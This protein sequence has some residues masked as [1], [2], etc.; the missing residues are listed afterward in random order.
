MSYRRLFLVFASVAQLGALS[1][2]RQAALPQDNSKLPVFAVSHPVQREVTDYVEYTGRTA[3]VQAEEIK[4][5]VTGFLVE[6]SFQEGGEIKKDDVLFKIDPRPYQAQ[7]DQAEA[8]VGLYQSQLKLAKANY[9]R[10][11]E[12][13]KRTKGAG[14]T[15]QALDSDVAQQEQAEAAL[16]A[17]QASLEVYKLNLDY[18]TVKSPIDGQAGR[19]NQPQG[20]LI[21]QDSTLLTTVQTVDP[22][23]A[24]FDMDM[25]SY[26]K[27]QLGM[28][29]DPGSKID[30]SMA[31]QG[32]E[33][34]PRAGHVDFFNN[35]VNPATDTLLARGVFANPKKP[36]G[37]EL[38]P[39]MFVRVNLPISRPH[40]AL[41]VIDQA[42][43]SIQGRKN[44]YVVDDQ[45]TVQELPVTIGQL[46]SDGLRVVQGKGLDDK[47]RVVVSKLLQVRA[48]TR[49][50]PVLQPMP[51]YAG[52]EPAPPAQAPAK[53]GKEKG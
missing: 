17:A 1:G 52:A 22:M 50:Q 40:Q 45:D 37:R 7:F 43:T 33:G 42:I 14:V 44:L 11:L 36:T 49:I 32:E 12:L 3:A 48:K 29:Q 41:L 25:P 28:S 8:Q 35:L 46:Q 27:F 53:K 47:T 39:G 16:K 6:M 9:Q 31:L 34:Y 4:A 26:R 13:F 5:R 23:Y 18:T 19:Y 2:C 38:K 30:V 51:T 24:Y 10:D 21:M 20:N 15:Q